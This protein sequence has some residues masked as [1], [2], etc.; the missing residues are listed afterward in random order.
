MYHMV[1]IDISATSPH[2]PAALWPFV[3]DAESWAR[4]GPFEEATLEREGRAERDGIGAV[5]RFRAG[6]HVS[7]EEVVAFHAPEHLAYMLLSGLPLRGY[8]GDVTLAPD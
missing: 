5:R 7:R 3:S 2:S 8:R 4:W 1:H 6:R